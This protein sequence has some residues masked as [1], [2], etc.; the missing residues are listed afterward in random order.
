[1][2]WEN[3]FLLMFVCDSEVTSYLFY[4]IAE[5]TKHDVTPVQLSMKPGTAAERSMFQLPPNGNGW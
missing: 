3:W 2:V 4:Y 5:T 1:V